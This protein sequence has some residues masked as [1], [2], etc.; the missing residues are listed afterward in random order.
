[1]VESS[2][3]VV[4]VLG[5]D[6]LRRKGS[7]ELEPREADVPVGPPTTV[8]RPAVLVKPASPQSDKDLI[9]EKPPVAARCG[10]DGILEYTPD[11]GRITRSPL[12]APQETGKPKEAPVVRRLGRATEEEEEE[13]AEDEQNS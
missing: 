5:K 10:P 7:E 12:S 8:E 2:Y 11:G 9:A 3:K 1:M 6:G 13:A 4:Y